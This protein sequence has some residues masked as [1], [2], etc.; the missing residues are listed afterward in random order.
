MSHDLLTLARVAPV[1][2]AAAALAAACG[3]SPALD[4]TYDFAENLSQAVLRLET[5]DVNFGT[6][7]ARAHLQQGWSVDEQ[8]PDGLPIVWAVGPAA[9]LWFDRFTPGP[10]NVRFRSLELPYADRAQTLTI[11]VNGGEAGAVSTRKNTGAKP[12][13]F[14]VFDVQIPETLIRIGR[15]VVEF[16]VDHYY[17]PAAGQTEQRPLSLAWDFLRFGPPLTRAAAT[18]ADNALEI[19]VPARLDYYLPVPAHARIQVG[20]MRA[21]G[22]PVPPDALVL[23]VLVDW[24]EGAPPQTIDVAGA[25]LGEALDVALTHRPGGWAR[26]SFIAMG[27]KFADWPDGLELTGARIV[28]P[29]EPDQQA[30]G[31]KPAT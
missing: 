14:Q 7:P 10:V 2:I 21:L 27:S 20:S 12:D 3:G 9:S 15:N 28:A 24:D 29:A 5:R 30:A 6:P 26:V 4:W 18:A 25:A 8:M 1:A 22:N 13:Y 31:K 11:I 19:P 16:R 17:S 23:R